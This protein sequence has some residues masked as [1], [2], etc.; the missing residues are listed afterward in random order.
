MNI[1]HL[2]IHIIY[3]TST[4]SSSTTTC[5]NTSNNNAI[6]LWSTP[7]HIVEDAMPPNSLPILIDIAK[8]LEKKY[9]TTHRSNRGIKSWQ[10]HNLLRTKR[11]ADNNS[12]KVLVQKI[13][14]VA[15]VFLKNGKEIN[16]R[17]IDVASLWFNIN[18]EGDGHNIA[19]THSDSVISGVVYLQTSDIAKGGELV[20]LDPRSQVYALEAYN[21]WFGMA[22]NQ[23]IDPVLNRMVLFPSFVP[24]RVEAYESNRVLQEN[25]SGA[26]NASSAKNCRISISFN[27]RVLE[28]DLMLKD[29]VQDE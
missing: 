8:Y 27:I 11:E 12:V 16:E 3:I 7:I 26:S 13:K 25:T 5:N 4:R 6:H 22:R 15:T 29:E 18:Y 21:N 9:H 1:F 24:H 23:I 19:H 20:L 17:Q 2:L 10:S 14:D 28:Q